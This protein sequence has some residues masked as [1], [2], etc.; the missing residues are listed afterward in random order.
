MVRML[1]LHFL[2]MTELCFLNLSL[3]FFQLHA[4]HSLAQCAHSTT[5]VLLVI[6]LSLLCC[7]LMIEI[8]QTEL[9]IYFENC[10]R[11]FSRLCGIR[12]TYLHVHVHVIVYYNAYTY[13]PAFGLALAPG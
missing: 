13:A 4:V 6:G 10:Y 5:C 3:D 7:I 2:V 12:D 8:R 1:S 11:I 9:F